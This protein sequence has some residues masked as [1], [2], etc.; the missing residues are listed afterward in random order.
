MEY[1]LGAVILFGA[2]WEMEGWMICDGRILQISR[3]QALYSILGPQYGGDG[4]STFALPK[5]DAPVEGSTY[6]I[7]VMG[8]Y[9]R[10]K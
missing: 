3:Y 10:R 6:Q 2:K 7:C 9:P 8:I 1:I 4:R 5:I